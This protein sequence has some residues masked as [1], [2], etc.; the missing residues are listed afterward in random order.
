MT[1]ITVSSPD[2]AAR[3][4]RVM[5]SEWTKLRSI[6]S[7]Q[8]SVAVLIVTTIGIAGLICAIQANRWDQMM[9]M[10]RESLDLTSLSLN[11]WFLGQ[12]V[13]G[14]LGVLAV[15]AEYGSRMIRTTFAAV[16]QRRVVLLA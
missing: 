14:V 10:D 8:Y 5:R 16:P 9:P 11:G 6:R 12:L 2:R 15:T 3:L 7:T 13:V 1:A 4:R